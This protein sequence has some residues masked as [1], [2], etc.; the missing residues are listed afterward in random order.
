MCTTEIRS[1]LR[2]EYTAVSKLLTSV[3][4]GIAGSIGN[5]YPEERLRVSLRIARLKAEQLGAKWTGD[6]C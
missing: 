5:P 1:K 4:S 2:S 6:R 3:L